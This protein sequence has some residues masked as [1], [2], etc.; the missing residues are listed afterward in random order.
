MTQEPTRGKFNAG[1]EHAIKGEISDAIASTTDIVVDSLTTADH[2]VL[3]SA[4]V[5]VSR[6]LASDAVSARSVVGVGE[7]TRHEV[8]LAQVVQRARRATRSALWGLC[9]DAAAGAVGSKQLVGLSADTR[10]VNTAFQLR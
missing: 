8:A 6:T 10:A 9:A 3:M 4:N 1:F 2:S 5:K 7:A